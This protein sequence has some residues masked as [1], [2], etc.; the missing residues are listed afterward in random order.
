[1][2]RYCANL[3]WLFT[4]H[5]FLDRFA[6][7]SKAGFKGVEFSAPYD[8]AVKDL[9]KRLQDS[10]L[11]QVLIN[12]PA[13]DW[14]KGERGIACLPDRRKAF[15]EGVK[16]AIEYAQELGCTRI[17]CLSGIATESLAQ[18]QLWGTLI[19]N[20]NYAAEA[21]AKVDMMLLLEPINT[22]EMPGFFINTSAKALKAMAACGH[23]N[24]KLQ[25]DIYHMQ[26]AEG[27]LA[28]SIARLMPVIGHIQL[29]DNPGRHEPG[30]GEINFPYLLRHVE[31]LNYAGWIGCEFKPTGQTETCLSWMN[32]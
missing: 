12:L 14:A 23:P 26:R 6:F 10:G 17:N 19:E 3:G 20:L 31:S 1:M 18:T 13:G 21:L 28:A 15:R 29:A 2:L 32:K 27:E 11:E 16:L 25:Y 4:E 8:F 9:K 5:H 30:T 22:Y 7:A 24:I